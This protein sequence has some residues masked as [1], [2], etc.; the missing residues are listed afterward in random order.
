VL[1]TTVKPIGQYWE[2]RA[3]HFLMQRGLQLIARNFST[4]SGE[5]D[6]IMRD[7][8][9]VAFVEVRYRGSARFG[10]AIH[11]I[12]AAKQRKLKRCAAIFVSRQQAWSSY[13]CRFDVIAYDAA[14]GNGKPVWIRA[15][16]D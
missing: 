9:H 6:L 4:P 12:T 14:N 16:F 15:A 2:Q 5:I 3:E 7:A 1:G 13:P 11:S 10:G 8:A